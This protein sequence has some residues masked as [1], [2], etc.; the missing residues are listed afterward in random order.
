MD[1]YDYRDVNGRVPFPPEEYSARLKKIRTIMADRGIDLL[2][3]TSPEN[4]NY[5]S[6]WN[7]AWLKITSSQSWNDAKNMGIAIHVDSEEFILFDIG[8]EEGI[9]LNKTI[10]TKPRIKSEMP[11]DPIMHG[12]QYDGPRV[13]ETLMDVIVRDLKNEGWLK[14]KKVVAIEMGSAK[15]NRLV[16]EAFQHKLEN[17]G[18][19][20]I[21]GTD[22]VAIARKIKSPL[23]LEYIRKASSIADEAFYAVKNYLKEGITELE[24]VGEYTNAMCKAGGENMGIVNLCTFGEERFWWPHAP[25]SRRKLAV[26]DPIIIALAGVYN[27]YHAVQGRTFCFG[28]PSKEMLDNDRNSMKIL[29]KAQDIL[30]PNMLVKDFYHQMKQFFVDEGMWGDQYWIGGYEIGIAFPPDWVGEFTYDL[31]ADEDEKLRFEPG[32]AI[33]FETGFGAI[34]TIIVTDKKVEMLGKAPREMQIVRP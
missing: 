8:D 4:L 25:A 23:E 20:V 18:C 9:V 6:G 2:Y 10:C 33:D 26:N 30:K 16:S 13:G 32:M 34:E 7:G 19:K 1:K 22:I 12:K 3:V 5:I 21:D 24:L 17:E 14:D 31:F 28:E 27:R 29:N 15:P 11:G